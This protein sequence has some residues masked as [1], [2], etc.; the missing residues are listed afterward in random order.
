MAEREKT[1]ERCTGE[2]G[3]SLIELIVALAV[4]AIVLGAALPAMYSA[5]GL[6]RN[7]RNRSIAANLGSQEI[8]I[9][10]EMAS[11]WCQERRAARAAAPRYR[12]TRRSTC[13]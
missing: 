4:L 6:A 7:N 5:L 13:G 1:N 10:R 8:D 11:G 12:R 2:D 9:V 3:F